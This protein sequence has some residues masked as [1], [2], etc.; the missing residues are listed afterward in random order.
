MVVLRAFAWVLLLV[1]VISLVGDLTRSSTGGTLAAT[2]ML[3]IWKS[4]APQSLTAISWF[5]QQTVYPALWDS[6][7]VRVLLLPGWL[8]MGAVGVILALLSRKKRRVNIFA[9]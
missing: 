2:S 5:V 3:S 7:I 4:M 1:A 8:L 6:V 9:N